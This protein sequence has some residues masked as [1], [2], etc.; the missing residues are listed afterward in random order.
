MLCVPLKLP[1]ISISPTRTYLNA[2][3]LAADFFCC[4]DNCF[5]VFDGVL[6]SVDGIPLA[7]SCRLN[8]D[9]RL[10]GVEIDTLVAL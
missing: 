8:D 10:M 7:M 1:C 9:A 5:L 6:K 2:N 4:A 3:T